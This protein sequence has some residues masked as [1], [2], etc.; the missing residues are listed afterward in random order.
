MVR[1]F[2]P[3]CVLIIFPLICSLPNHQE[4]DLY[5]TDVEKGGAYIVELEN[6]SKDNSVHKL[7]ELENKINAKKRDFKLLDLDNEGNYKKIE[8]KRIYKRKLEGDSAPMYT[9]KKMKM[10]NIIR[11]DNTVNK[12]VDKEIYGKEDEFR[13]VGLLK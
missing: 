3:F 7:V 8:Y 5:L 13:T 9:E 1:F 2:G 6:E 12:K 4:K 11:F 10:K